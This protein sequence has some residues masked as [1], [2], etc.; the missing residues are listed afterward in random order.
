MFINFSNHPSSNWTPE[1][2][3]AAEI[4]GGEI[5]DVPF[6]N[7]PPTADQNEVLRIA[8]IQIAE[9]KRVSGRHFPDC[10]IMAQGEQTLCFAIISR[11]IV[12]HRNVKM[13]AATTERVVTTTKDGK[14]TYSFK[15]VQFR[16][17]V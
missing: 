11:I 7:V 4:I 1:Q 13:V 17:Y 6:P 15:F 16:P 10:T 8:Y 14:R 2:T 12:G 5:I 3:T 9:F